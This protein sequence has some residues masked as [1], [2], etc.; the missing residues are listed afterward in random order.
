MSEAAASPDPPVPPPAAGLDLQ[1][2]ALV[3][4]LFDRAAQAN[5]EAAN[6]KGATADLSG[7]GLLVMSGDLHDNGFNFQKLVQYAAL[8]ERPDRHLVLHEVIHGPARVNGRD[9]SVR[10]LAR[11]AALKLQYPDQVHL[12]L[13]NHELSQ[14]AGSSILKEGTSLVEAF[15]RGLEFLYDDQVHAVREAMKRFIYSMLLAVR[16]PNGILCSHSLPSPAMLA[17]FDPTV[18]DR[19]P[20]D[21]DLA[22][23]GSAYN[24]VWGRNHS[25]QLV[26]TLGEAWNVRLFVIGH[27]PVDMGYDTEGQRVLVVASDHEHGMA[28]PIDLEREYDLQ[29]LIGQMVPLASIVL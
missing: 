1:D 18:L 13:A 25:E 16:C 3:A 22:S 8:D 17:E 15:D 12:L 4:D 10:T 28:L 27:Q 21:E 2:P 6:R 19:V 9:L 5:L 26:Q 7:P 11:V 23:G 29:G 20:T 14:A 24:M